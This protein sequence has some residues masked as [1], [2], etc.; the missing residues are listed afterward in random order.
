MAFLSFS[1]ARKNK[2]GALSKNE[3]WPRGFDGVELT[4]AKAS[5]EGQ[6]GRQL[7]GADV[8]AI[9]HNVLH[10]SACV[11]NNDNRQSLEGQC[12]PRLLQSL[13]FCRTADESETSCP[14]RHSGARTLA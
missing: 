4:D 6:V 1:L 14:H 7:D 8:P 10:A 3:S 2:K 9:L 5:L 13:R 12:N 11:D